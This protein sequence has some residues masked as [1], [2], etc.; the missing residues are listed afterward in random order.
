[1]PLAIGLVYIVSSHSGL[2]GIY[3]THDIWT[4]DK[5]ITALKQFN[6][7]FSHPMPSSMSP[8]GLLIKEN[9][10]GSLLDLAKSAGIP[11]ARLR[12]LSNSLTAYATLSPPEL[13]A[14]AFALKMTPTQLKQELTQI[15]GN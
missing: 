6:L 3:S 1:L 14:L 7:R 8:L 5:T 12:S 4:I 2:S 11:P 9:Y 15:E 13:Y 10:P